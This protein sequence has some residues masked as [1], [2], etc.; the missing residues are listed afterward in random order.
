MQLF[1]DGEL[2]RTV[3]GVGDGCSGPNVW[4]APQ[5]NSL[6]IGA[7]DAQPNNAPSVGKMWFDDIAVGTTG[8]LGCPA[9]P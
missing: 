2:K 3:D 5:F 6:A 8:R 1:I 4:T 9:P 7:Y